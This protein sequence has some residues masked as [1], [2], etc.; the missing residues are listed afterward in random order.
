[1]HQLTAEDLLGYFALLREEC[2]RLNIMDQRIGI[3]DGKFTHSNSN[4]NKVKG[5]DAY[6]DPDAG[7]GRHN[8]VKKGVGY[9]CRTVYMYMGNHWLPFY[10][11]VFPA[12]RNDT[13]A[14]KETFIA[15]NAVFPLWGMILLCDAGAY[16]EENLNF[17]RG[18]GVVLIIR[19]K[20]NLKD[21]NVR[22]LKPK[23]FFNTTFFPENWSDK[24]LLKMYAIRPRIEE[25]NAQGN[26]Q[27]NGKRMNIRGKEA[28]IKYITLIYILMFTQGP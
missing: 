20:K 25:G 27:Y 22:E 19:G 21:P 8:G 16:S 9:D 24:D 2:L 1:M 15:M 14:F 17:C 12:N 3:W 18:L 4:N 5:T 26:G 13:Q 7:Y 11:Q 23:Y 6:S 10:F 28:T